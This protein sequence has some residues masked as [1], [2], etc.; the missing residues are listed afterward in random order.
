M[1]DDEKNG[2]D[3]LAVWNDID[4]A[5]ETEYHRWYW[6][7]HLPERLSVPGF[8]SAYRYQAVDA[9]PRF[10]TWYLVRDIEILRSQ[11]YLERLS[12]PTE[13]TQRV[14]PWFRNMT[15]CACRLTANF[16]RGIGGTLVVMRCEGAGLAGSMRDCVSRLYESAGEASL[17]RAQLW[18]TDREI[19]AQRTPEQALRGGADR[20]IDCAIVLHCPS[21][22]AA[23][24]VSKQLKE[25][26]PA[27]LGGAA[28][29]GPHIYTLLHSLSVIG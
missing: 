10:F 22:E 5:H 11:P 13:W 2:V 12:S 7:Q 1:T 20:L 15:R 26:L 21:V 28:L 14:M 27:N 9:S 25:L 29:D 17:T 3:V 24:S 6:K 16:G 18:V 4:P 23:R 8:M 19:S